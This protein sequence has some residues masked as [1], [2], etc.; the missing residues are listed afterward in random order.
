MKSVISIGLFYD[1]TNALGHAILEQ[2]QKRSILL[3][4]KARGAYYGA[5][6]AFSPP[7]TKKRKESE[8]SGTGIFGFFKALE[9]AHLQDDD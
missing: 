7:K 8:S 1:L 6:K 3:D 5:K 4:F 2:I 9:Q